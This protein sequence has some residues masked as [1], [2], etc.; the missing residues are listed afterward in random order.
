MRFRPLHFP[1]LPT[2]ATLGIIPTDYKIALS[3]EEQLL[4]L[5]KH[6][7]DMDSNIVLV[8]E[9]IDDLREYLE[10]A[11]ELIQNSVNTLA[12]DVEGKQ[13][14]LIA[15][16]N[17]EIE[18]NVISA[19]FLDEED[20]TTDIVP[21]YVVPLSTFNVGD[22]VSPVAIAMEDDGY[23][24]IPEC[25]AGDKFIITGNFV[26]GVLDD[27]NI[28]LEKYSEVGTK[29]PYTLQNDGKVI[30]SFTHIHD[31]LYELTE[32]NIADINST[33]VGSIV[34]S[35]VPVVFENTEYTSCD[36]TQGD[37]FKITG[38]YTLAVLDSYN[39]VLEKDT[40]TNGE[41]VIE[42]TGTL[43]VNYEDTNT[44]PTTYLR[45]INPLK[46]K[47]W[48]T[49]DVVTLLNSKQ[50]KLIAGDNITLTPTDDGVVI[51]ATGGSQGT[52]DYDELNN[53][54]SINSV[55]L[56]GNKTAHELRLASIDDYKDLYGKQP[57]KTH[58]IGSPATTDSIEGFVRSFQL[59]GKYTQGENPSSANPQTIY[60]CTGEYRI[61]FWYESGG[62]QV[63][64]FINL[65]DLELLALPMEDDIDYI[66][67]VMMIGGTISWYL[68][69]ATGKIAS[70]N[71]ESITTTYISS[72]GGLDTG[73]TIYYQLD[74]PT[75]I[76]IT[77]SNY[78][79]LYTQLNDLLDFETKTKTYSNIL[80]SLNHEVVTDDRPTPTTSYEY[81]LDINKLIDTKQNKLTSGNAGNGIE[82]N[83]EKIS[84]I[85]NSLIS[86]NKID[87][88]PTITLN[89][90]IQKIQLNNINLINGDSFT[91]DTQNNEIICNKEMYIRF[92]V[93]CAINNGS[94]SRN[95]FASLLRNGVSMVTPWV[96][97]QSSPSTTL[98]VRDGITKVNENDK[99]TLG[100]GADSSTSIT[101]SQYAISLT[102]QEIE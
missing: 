31:N 34:E 70:Y 95:Y 41:Y 48:R 75:I 80:N 32:G 25:K 36:V 89:S 35:L 8:D 85:P 71:G 45:K 79:E 91:F 33:D 14:K 38:K 47:I 90:T 82:I 13:D 10:G 67:P 102:I 6:I 23:I 62:E 99:L 98:I 44:Y 57:Y 64:K 21:D 37:I 74:N 46:P 68:Q 81:Y 2:F 49:I 17:I 7:E 60:T 20:Y 9:K 3:Y 52:T 87:S 56:Q 61:A 40:G 93:F 88:A 43:Y 39:V 12:L 27:D 78:P 97:G 63:E 26:L 5:C 69:K 24:E 101:L 65:G 1:F 4:W 51:S 19:K 66:F 18:N 73:A 55:T 94:T 86:I 42:N 96:R 28:L 59:E 15:G 92:N 77:S 16:M 54:P 50:D 29:E 11:L 83:N 72:T 84:K 30:V 53:K 76:E 22:E 58:V 100:M